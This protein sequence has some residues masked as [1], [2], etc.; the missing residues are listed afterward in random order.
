[1][2]RLIL[3]VV[4][5]CFA[6]VEGFLS[7]APVAL[8]GSGRLPC[9]SMHRGGRRMVPSQRAILMAQQLNQVT[10]ALHALMFR[11]DSVASMKLFGFKTVDENHKN[12]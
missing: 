10:M 6:R 1:M 9:C 4:L 11:E 12:Q 7:R 8:R 3:V 5:L 2:A